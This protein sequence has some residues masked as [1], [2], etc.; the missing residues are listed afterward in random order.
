M[1]SGAI[2]IANIGC[3]WPSSVTSAFWGQ[4]GHDQRRLSLSLMTEADEQALAEPL[5]TAFDW[6]VVSAVVV[7]SKILHPAVGRTSFG[8]VTWLQDYLE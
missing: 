5:A 8:R 7:A 4:S 2:E 1:H 6:A 3:L